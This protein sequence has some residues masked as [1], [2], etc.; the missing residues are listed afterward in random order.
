[1]RGKGIGWPLL[2][3]L[4]AAAG[5]VEAVESVSP[6]VVRLA[7]GEREL[8]VGETLLVAVHVTGIPEPG[9]AAFQIVVEFDPAVLDVRN[10]NAGFG[11][12]PAF[13]PLGG[14]RLCAPVRGTVT[15]EDPEWLLEATGR[16]PV[17]TDSIDPERGIVTIAYGTA[18]YHSLT[19]GGV[20]IKPFTR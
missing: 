20:I 9:V 11:G 6:T 13:R 4:V 19:S 14:S 12:I 7:A 17:G 8:A 18:C 10:P 16:Q 2:A 5:L 15:C 3:L 1:M